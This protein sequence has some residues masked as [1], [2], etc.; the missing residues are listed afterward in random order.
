[1]KLINQI[2]YSL[3]HFIGFRVICLSSFWV[4]VEEEEEEFPDKHGDTWGKIGHV[5]KA[6]FIPDRVKQNEGL[7]TAGI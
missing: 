3:L 5:K 7:S 1:M 2:N 6:W 4:E